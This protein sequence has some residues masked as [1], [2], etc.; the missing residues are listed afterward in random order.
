L[1]YPWPF[2]GPW[3]IGDLED[4]DV[5]D[6]SDRSAE[7]RF[8]RA[9]TAATTRPWAAWFAARI[10]AFAVFGITVLLNRGNVFYD[11]TFY[12]RW[13]TKTLDGS[14][15]PYADFAWEYP[16]AALPAMMPPALLTWPLPLLNLVPYALAW[17]AMV[18]VLDALITRALIA[19]TGGRL[20]HPALQLWILGL[21]LLGALSWARFDLFPA[22]AALAAIVYAGSRRERV[23]GLAAGVG[24]SLKL[25]PAL[26]APIQR[27]RRSAVAATAVAVGVVAAFAGITYALTGSSGFS[28]VLDYQSERGLQIESLAGLPLV[29]LHHLGVDGYT[30]G[31]AFGAWEINGP[32]ASTLADIATVVF[33]GGL[34]LIGLAHWRLMKV[35][36]G[37]RGVALSAVALLLVSLVTNKVFSPQYVLWLFAAVVAAALLDPETWRPYVRPVLLLAA[38]THLV[39][40]LFYG[41]VL[42]GAWIG[43][44]VMTARDLLLLVLLVAVGLRLAREVATAKDREAL[45][46]SIDDVPDGD[47]S[48]QSSSASSR[49]R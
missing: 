32:G 43:L 21:P 36:A 44:V 25:W 4:F 10:A 3:P 37:R 7:S 12:G 18:L 16:P 19:R 33:L 45:I 20:A 46:A 35:D 5:P 22:A 40:P 24:A 47:Q 23:S 34:A 15:I 1:S 31:F 29:W 6:V 30:T 9:R 41:D 26:L 2:D 8:S 42:Y 49:A 39:F 38:L 13:A 48:S 17:I 14:R 28:Q 27:T 11:L